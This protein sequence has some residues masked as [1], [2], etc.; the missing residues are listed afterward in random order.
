MLSIASLSRC[1]LRTPLSN[2]KHTFF[3][4]TG[5]TFSKV[6]SISDHH[7]THP[8]AHKR[9]EVIWSILSDHDELT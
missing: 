8:K 7:K 2:R 3:S 1:L 6:D 5:E 4:N 9:V